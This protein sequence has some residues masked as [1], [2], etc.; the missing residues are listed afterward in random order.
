MASNPSHPFSQ[1]FSLQLLQI[2]RWLANTR[3]PDS[4]DLVALLNYLLNGGGGRREE[5]VSR[6]MGGGKKRDGRGYGRG[7]GGGNGREGRK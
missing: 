3:Q 6:K 2:V 7:G 5:E 1:L 4:P